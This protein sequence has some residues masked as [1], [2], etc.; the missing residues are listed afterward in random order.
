MSSVSVFIR[1]EVI[2]YNADPASV[3]YGNLYFI[4]VKVNADDI[5]GDEHF[6]ILQF[7]FR[8]IIL[9]ELGEIGNI[10]FHRVFLRIIFCLFG[11]GA[12]ASGEIGVE[13][14]DRGVIQKSTTTKKLLRKD[15]EKEAHCKK[16]AEQVV[17]LL[18]IRCIR[19]S[20]F[21]R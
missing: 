2:R 20:I 10:G 1:Q 12:V 8:E 17:D 16:I 21:Q 14:I 15:T 18:G 4:T 5:E 13:D 3:R 19:Y 11:S 9:S 6:S 7:K